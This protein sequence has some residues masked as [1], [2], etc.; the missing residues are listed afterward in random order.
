MRQVL[1]HNAEVVLPDGLLFGGV[2][3]RDQGIATVFAEHDK[4]TGF[5][6][7]QTID[8]EGCY[9]A[10]GLID[11]HLHGSAGV[12][13]QATDHA[14]LDALGEFLAASGVTAYVPTFVPTDDSGYRSALETIRSYVQSDSSTRLTISNRPRARIMGVH[15]EG[16][17]VSRHRCGALKREHFRTYNGESGAIDLFA[18]GINR[19]NERSTV[20]LMTI[21]PEV[22]GGVKLIRRL[23]AEGARAFI[24]HSQA[25]PEV[26]KSAFDAGARHITHFPNALDPLHH[27]KPGAVG[28]SLLHDEVTLDCIADFQH[29]DPLMLKLIFKTKG[30]SR[31]AL[32]SDA[33]KPTG[34]GDGD[35]EVWDELIAVRNGRTSLAGAATETIAGS[36]ITM[37]AAVRNVVSLGVGVSDAIEMASSIPARIAGIRDRGSIVPGK[38]ADLIALSDDLNPTLTIVGGDLP[39]KAH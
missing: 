10:P 35:F 29:V 24:G 2:L 30:L 14:G 6:E 36:V 31:V 27:R 21:A 12:D 13:V 5:E 34:L 32:I 8:L 28:W 7:S 33:I 19:P 39:G 17:F 22:D 18:Q 16:P 23:S 26:L 25:D 1:I 20:T 37:I 3:I 38:R 4:P 15:F 11:I 9:L